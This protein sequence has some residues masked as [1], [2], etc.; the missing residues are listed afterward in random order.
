[1][2]ILLVGESFRGA[3]LESIYNNLLRFGVEAEMIN[4]HA[5]FETS[6]L[7]RVLN[8]F[9]KTPH[10]FGRE[11]KEVNKAILQKASSGHFD[12]VLFFKPI[13][14]YPE[15]ISKIKKYS[16]VIGFYNDH[17]N[18]LKN[19]SDYFYASIPLFDLYFMPSLT[20]EEAAEAS[21]KFGCKIIPFPLALADPLCHH[22][23]AITPEEKE[24]LGADMVFLG[25]YAPENRARYLERLCREGY[26]VK[27]YGNGWNKLPWNSCLRR[28]KRI[29]PGNTPCEEMAKIIAA[30]KIILAFMRDQNKEV[31]AWRTYEIP[32]C[33]GFM[34]HQRTKQA[35]EF[36]VPD[37]EAVFF[38][39]YEEMKNKIDF[40]LKYPELRNK[41]AQAGYQRVLN[42]GRLNRDQ[43]KKM[44]E[45]LKNE[46]GK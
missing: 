2:K 4:T 41:I 8:K 19:G 7:N 29:I 46:F 40:Y 20:N 36:L 6:F 14:I 11:V 5:F 15:T 26:D 21:R 22:P 13:L 10:Y 33:G 18:F 34:L 35:E 12:F 28:K 3:A 42:C 45:I 30:S 17:I 31:I 32:L 9:L 44:I 43:V 37:Q 24:K 27:I 23:V 39:S 1:M 16:K 25:T 38:G